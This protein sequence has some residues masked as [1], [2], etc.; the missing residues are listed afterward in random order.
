M[1]R[2]ARADATWH[3]RH[4]GRATRAHVGTY[5]ALMRC[6]HMAAPREY[7]WMPGWCL[8]GKR[9]FG[10]ASDGPTGIVGQVIV[11]GR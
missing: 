4:R 5:V 6:R 11:L 8:R 10:L 9:V 7:M 2:G 3:A 1:W